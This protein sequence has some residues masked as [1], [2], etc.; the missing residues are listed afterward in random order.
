MTGGVKG[1][2]GGAAGSSGI[3]IGHDMDG[4][5]AGFVP[6]GGKRGAD[7]GQEPVLEAGRGL[8][9]ATADDERVRVEGSDHLIKEDSEAMGLR[10]EKLAG[11]WVAFFGK[12]AHEAGS[13]AQVA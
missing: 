9:G 12:T 10:G 11:E 7:L 3:A 4:N 8:N 6:P 13:F 5:V 1:L 2:Q